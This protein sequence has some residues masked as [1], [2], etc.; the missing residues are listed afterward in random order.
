MGWIYL[1]S[2]LL[3]AVRYHGQTLH[4]EVEFRDG[5]A[6]RYLHVPA[7]T[8]EALLEAESKGEYFNH[9]IRKRF[10]SAKIQHARAARGGAS[11]QD[12][13]RVHA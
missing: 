10:P 5:S 3:R 9:Q 4:L 1:N 11:S 7:D 6:Y 13:E 8:F 12:E 2:S